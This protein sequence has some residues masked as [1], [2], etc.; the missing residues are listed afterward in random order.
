MIR[1]LGA[2]DGRRT[3]PAQ[4]LAQLGNM[5]FTQQQ[6]SIL[7]TK[8]SLVQSAAPWIHPGLSS[9]S[10]APSDANSFTVT[11]APSGSTVYPFVAYPAP[12]AG[13]VNVISFTVPPSKVALIRYLSISHYGGNDPSGTGQVIWR[14]LQNGGGLQGL[15]SL[16]VTVGTQASPQLLPAPIVGMENDTII[17]TVEVAAGFDPMGQG[18]GTA[19]AFWGF[20]YPLS[21]ATSPTPGSY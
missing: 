21:A 6:K 17:V 1:R 16:S 5:P 14:V 9:A 18:Q 2:T 8:A 7:N 4:L 3:R 20:A 11:T 19:A 10:N 15:N 12:G 13:P